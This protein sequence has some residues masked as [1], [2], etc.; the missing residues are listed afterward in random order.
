[1]LEALGRFGR[2]PGGERLAAILNEYAPTWLA[3]LPTLLS[4]RELEAVQRRGQGATRERM[5][6][7]LTEALDVMT[8]EHPLVLVLEDLHWGDPSTV[9]LLAA[10]ARRREAA[11]LLVLGTYR[12]VELVVTNHPLKAVKHE[13]VARGQGTE[14]LLGNLSREAVRTYVARRLGQ[15]LSGVRRMSW[16]RSCIS[17]P[18]GIRSSWC[19]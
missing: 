7:E 10:L 14:I 18:R 5:L 16:R 15:P 3:Q 17:A 4:P 8:A 1:V 9:E 19:R 6:R 13:L 2:Q 12:P 11:R